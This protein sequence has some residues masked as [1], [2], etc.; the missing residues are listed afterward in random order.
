LILRGFFI[1][2][3]LKTD[4]LAN[5]KPVLNFTGNTLLSQESGNNCQENF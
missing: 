5:S 2:A 1:L 4:T 3:N